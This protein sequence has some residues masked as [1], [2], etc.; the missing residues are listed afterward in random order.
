MM[1][2]MM[3]MVMMMMMYR[4][5][6]V[7][8]TTADKE[9][10]GA[11][12]TRCAEQIRRNES[13]GVCSSDHSI[14]SNRYDHGPRTKSPYKEQSSPR[15]INAGSK[16]KSSGSDAGPSA[17]THIVRIEQAYSIMQVNRRGNRHPRRHRAGGKG[18][19]AT[20]GSRCVLTK[21]RRSSAS[22]EST[23]RYLQSR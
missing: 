22:Y 16:W 20:N 14:E 21:S 11:R 8:C 10:C 6:G 9:R 18:E 15:R 7:L 1:P 2:T 3:M 4:G 12:A 13:M 19:N 17:Y 23:R 5:C